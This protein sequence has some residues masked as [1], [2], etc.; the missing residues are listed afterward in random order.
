MILLQSTPLDTVQNAKDR[1]QLAVGVEFGTLPPYLYALYSIR[2]GANSAAQKSLLAVALEEMIHMCLVCNVLNALGGHPVIQVQKYP[3]PLPGEIGPNQVQLI[4]HLI[5]FSQDAMKQGMNIEEPEDAPDFPVRSFLEM[6][7]APATT[8][9]TIGQFY[10]ELDSFLETL[11]ATSWTPNRNQITDSQ[12]FAG[13]VFP[14]NNYAD[15]HR[16]ITNI[17]SEGE[18]T[19]SG[20]THDPLDFQDEIAHFFRFGEIFNDRVLTKT[21]DPLGYAFGPQ[22]FGVDWNGAYPAISD[23]GAHDFSHDPPAA[24]A[25]QTACNQAFTNLIDSLQLAVNGSAGALGD[26]VQAMFALRMAALH[27]F[28]VP[29]ADPAKVAGPAFLY[30]PKP[31][32]GNA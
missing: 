2:P 23:P 4:L 7:A 25:A 1:L 14:V 9:V 5:P 26:A 18:G 21:N 30:Q 11:P 24:Q 13:Q 29:L 12:F 17:V 6:A 20:T 10:R 32:G 15:A 31:A 3:G 8:A 22:K 27:A 16:A 28:T 19:Q